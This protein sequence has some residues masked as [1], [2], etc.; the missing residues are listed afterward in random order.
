VLNPA[1]KGSGEGIRLGD[2]GYCVAASMPIIVLPEAVYAQGSLF[3]VKLG[4]ILSVGNASSVRLFGHPAFVADVGVA[5]GGVHRRDD[6]PR[7]RT[8]AI[9]HGE[10]RARGSVLI[11]VFGRRLNAHIR[12]PGPLEV[13]SAKLFAI[14]LESTRF[15][16]TVDSLARLGRLFAPPVRVVKNLS[17][18]RLHCV[19]SLGN[20]TRRIGSINN[21][22]IRF[23]AVARAHMGIMPSFRNQLTPIRKGGSD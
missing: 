10:P 4:G 20:L 21:T 16:V 8:R 2:A 9:G 5:A 1:D 3:R 12:K 17:P 23:Q 14:H 22:R 19:S 18:R 15:P 6:P 11:N 7:F 13:E